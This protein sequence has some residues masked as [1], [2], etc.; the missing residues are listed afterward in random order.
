[1]RGVLEIL[2]VSFLTFGAELHLDYKALVV[3][4]FLFF[5][6][7]FGKAIMFGCL[8]LDN[9]PKH[10]VILLKLLLILIRKLVFRCRQ[11]VVVA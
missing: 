9:L 8:V 10:L 2:E 11:N 1:M 7:H 6:W 4:F 5:F 3:Y